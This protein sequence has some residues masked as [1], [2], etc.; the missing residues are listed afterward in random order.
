MRTATVPARPPAP[1]SAGPASVPAGPAS[2]P[3]GAAFRR[4]RPGRHP[5]RTIALLMIGL[6]LVPVPG[7]VAA[8][9]SRS[10]APTAGFGW[11]LAPPHPVLRRF[12]PPA[13]RYG[14]GHRGVDLGAPAGAPV[15]AAG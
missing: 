15:L 13:T 9:P 2:V 7:A 10:T 11:P 5:G 8:A 4:A 1:R 14:R 3:T 12:D 6:L